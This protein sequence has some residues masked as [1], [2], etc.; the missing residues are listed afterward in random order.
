MNIAY[1]YYGPEDGKGLQTK[2]SPNLHN[3]LPEDTIIEL[4]N[5]LPSENPIKRLHKTLAGYIVSI[6]FVKK[7]TDSHGRQTIKNH[8]FVLPLNDMV[9]D[10]TEKLALHVGVLTHDVTV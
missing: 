3:L 1:L 5:L 2:E 6:S 4:L 7:A 9:N 8:T 10:Y